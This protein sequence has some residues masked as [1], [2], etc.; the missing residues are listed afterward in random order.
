M[1]INL[2]LGNLSREKN[3]KL[4]NKLF[5]SKRYVILNF[6]QFILKIPSTPTADSVLY[7]NVKMLEEI[8]G[9]RKRLE[10]E[11]KKH[12]EAADK[13]KL[14]K[15]ER[16]KQGPAENMSVAVLKQLLKDKGITFSSKAK[17]SELVNLL[18]TVATSTS[19]NHTT[20]SQRSGMYNTRARKV[21]ISANVPMGV[22]AA[23]YDGSLPKPKHHFFVEKQPPHEISYHLDDS[24]A[25]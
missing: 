14:E 13:E 6:H 15:I 16:M 18:N 4:A 20:I 9:H 25:Y 24:C 19:Q 3:T 22:N 1:A 21:I 11:Q 17:N 23:A 2:F 10:S 12:K 7:L 8:E 5:R